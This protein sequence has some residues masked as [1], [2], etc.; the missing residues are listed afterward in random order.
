MGD[1]LHATAAKHLLTS[2]TLHVRRVQVERRILRLEYDDVVKVALQVHVVRSLV[3]ERSAEV[4]PDHRV[5]HPVGGLAAGRVPR[6]VLLLDVL[7]DVLVLCVLV[8]RVD[9]HLEC[10]GWSGCVLGQRMRN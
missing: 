4:F 6:V 2:A 10:V 9:R 7:R 5:I 8:E 1:R 3:A